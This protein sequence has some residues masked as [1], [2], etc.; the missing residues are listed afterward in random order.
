[1]LAFSL[2]FFFLS[3]CCVRVLPKRKV[4]LPRPK[5]KANTFYFWLACSSLFAFLS[6][7]LFFFFLRCPLG[8]KTQVLE[9]TS[10]LIALSHSPFFDSHARTHSTH[11]LHAL[12]LFLLHHELKPKRRFAF[13]GP[14]APKHNRSNR[15]GCQLESNHHQPALSRA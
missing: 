10:R 13:F 4:S 11:T 14:A 5:R 9:I 3:C 1:M 15:S 12:C 2:A 7:S 6:F 8:V